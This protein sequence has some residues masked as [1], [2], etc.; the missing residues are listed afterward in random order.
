MIWLIVLKERICTMCEF[1]YKR[2][3][4]KCLLVLYSL[5]MCG[6][7][8][9]LCFQ[10][11]SLI[12]EVFLNG[13]C[14]FI[15]TGD[16]NVGIFIV[17]QRPCFINGHKPFLILKKTAY[18]MSIGFTAVYNFYYYQ[19]S[20]NVR[21]QILKQL[22]YRQVGIYSY[23]TCITSIGNLPIYTLKQKIIISI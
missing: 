23:A 7:F 8:K 21:N 4:T 18:F 17:K 5:L 6:P 11:K 1:Y 20:T 15:F 10:C 14:K 2:R 9:L 16:L 3:L 19:I 13:V 12:N 22:K